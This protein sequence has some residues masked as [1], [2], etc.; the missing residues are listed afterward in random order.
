MFHTSRMPAGI[1]IQLF[2]PQTAS[3]REWAQLHAYRRARHHEDQP[4]EPL[5]PEAD[6]EHELMQRHPLFEARRLMAIRDG[7]YVGNLLLGFRRD[8]SPGCEDHAAFVDAGGGVLGGLRRQGIG[9][10]L[11]AAL[12][13]FMQGS[14]RTVATLKVHRPEG[15]AFMSAIGA[16]EKY[17]SVE[18]RLALEGLQ[19]SELAQWQAH[20]TAPSNGLHWETHAGRVPFERLGQ[21]MEPLSV[22]INEQPL[23]SLEIPRIRYELQGYESWYAAMD[24]R[25][26]DHFLVMLLHGKDLAAVCDASWDARFADRV[27]QQ[28]TAVASPWRGKGLAKGVKAAMFDLV[29]KWHPEVRTVITNNANTNAAM[30]SI[31]RRLGFAAHRQD[32]TWQVSVDALGRWLSA[33]RH[34]AG[35]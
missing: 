20:A 17:R 2:D 29:R 1:Q 18:N 23:G 34:G 16:R 28:L 24:R 3:R 5:T 6:F 14:G 8:G 12:H 21:L 15:H 22:L 19:W 11:L 4:G 10:A 27:Y 30:L 9:T 31:N 25:G 13:T 33:S 26:G 32:A 35:D 7:G